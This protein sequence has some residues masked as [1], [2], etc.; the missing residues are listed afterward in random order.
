MEKIVYISSSTQDKKAWL[1]TIVISFLPV[2]FF[3]WR[4]TTNIA[5]NNMQHAV[6]FGLLLA[7]FSIIPVLGFLNT[8]YKYILTN[9]ELIIK[10]QIK[11]TVIPWASISQIRLMTKE[12]KKGMLRTFGVEGAFG[13]Y[14]KYQSLKHKKLFVNVRRYTNWTLIVTNGKKY[15]IA[16]DD[17]QLIE[18]AI[19]LIGQPETVDKNEVDA[20]TDWQRKITTIVLPFFLVFIT[21]SIFCTYMERRIIC[22]ETHFQLNGIYG[23]SIGMDYIAAADTIMWKEMPEISMR[24]NGVSLPGVHRGYFRTQDGGKIKLNV[25]TGVNPVIRIIENDGKVHYINRKN[26]EETRQIFEKLQNVIKK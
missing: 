26:P 9:T 18:V 5:C 7:L 12:D 23:V 4:L 24:S 15:V 13:A 25:R 10:R 22:D 8:P 3:G 21:V 11:D 1:L 16:P 14:G 6:M 17:I 20:K 19:K 2:L